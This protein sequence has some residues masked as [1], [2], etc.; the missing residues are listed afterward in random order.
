[1]KKLYE[2][3]LCNDRNRTNYSD[4]DPNNYFRLKCD[5]GHIIYHLYNLEK[6]KNAIYII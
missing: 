2:K 3:N 6:R 4:A 1:V 5:H